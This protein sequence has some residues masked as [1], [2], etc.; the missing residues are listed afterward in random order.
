MLLLSALLAL[1][2][3]GVVY[4][5][6][7]EQRIKS[8]FLALCAAVAVGLSGFCV[9]V[10]FPEWSVPAARI[11]MTTGL[12]IAICSFVSVQKLYGLPVRASAVA[13]MAAAA[14]VTVATVW[15]TDAYFSGELIRYPWGVVVGGDP[16]FLLNPLLVAAIL[17]WSLVNLWSLYRVADPM[18]RNR[19]KYLFVANLAFPVAAMDYLLHFGIDLFGGPITAISVPVFLAI[20]GYA[21][22]RYR[23]FE[24]RALVGR[25][26]GWLL[27]AVLLAV[28]YALVVEAGR[29]FG[30]FPERV[31]VAA[32]LI[33]FALWVGL[34]RQMPAWTERL[35]S[36]EPDFM[37][38]VSRFSDEVVA[39]QD[40]GTL[41]SKWVELC[42]STFSTEQAW[43]I[44]SD[45]LPVNLAEVEMLEQQPVRRAGG[46]WPDAAA[47]A[48][49]LFPLWRGEVLLGAL[50][51]GPRRQ[52]LIYP[53]RALDALRLAA[54][55]FS[56]AL[57]NIFAAVEIEKRHQLDRY[58]APQ[59]I[60]GLLGARPDA[61]E[62]KRRSTITVF[63]SDVI[64]FSDLADR[65]DPDALSVVMNDYLAEMA[66]VAFAY[67]G[68]VDKFIG[69]SVMVLFGA[70]IEESIGKQAHQCVA[71]ACEMHR[72]T[73][74]LNRRWCEAGL[75]MEG[76]A[77]RMGVHTGEA[78]VGTFGS[79]TRV[80]YTALG[81][82]VNL[83]SRLEGGC[84]PGRILVSAETWRH[85]DGSFP[86]RCRGAIVVKG[87][88]EPI[89]A[90]EIDPE[91]TQP[92]DDGMARETPSRYT[93]GSIPT[94]R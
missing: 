81:R 46:E 38:A 4:A 2:V 34:A 16:K 15:L 67:G 61:L 3:G 45:R 43:F 90:Y 24:F 29:R 70:P 87:F 25:T 77:V 5:V 44:E 48:E 66:D 42:A 23:L 28:A 50:A 6:G 85:L 30:I 83:A 55:M 56:A 49:L 32:A 39:I 7:Q 72:H 36:G 13:L 59:V 51:A 57:A 94:S 8:W 35:L 18:D 20:Y 68:T 65:L 54:K 9:E 84:E 60:D 79:R 86:G 76:L 47:Q 88:A 19:A 73:A 40:A 33:A 71:M 91:E 11:N 69:D 41:Q 26:S 17:L 21:M 37:G 10:N 53:Q 14:A 31:H 22:L 12:V 62:H 58:L 93:T 75:L 89:E 92:E 1:V 27:A 52:G 78:T 74:A 82:A 80:E 63:F 64:R